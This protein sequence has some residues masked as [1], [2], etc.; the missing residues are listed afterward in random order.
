MISFIRQNIYYRI[1]DF[2]RNSS[3]VKELPALK[4]I[5]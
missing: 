2:S 3:A 5:K 1:K 4:K